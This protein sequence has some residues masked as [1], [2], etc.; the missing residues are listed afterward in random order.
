MI[1][2]NDAYCL[3]HPDLIH[4]LQLKVLQFVG[5]SIHYV[6]RKKMLINL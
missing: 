6:W 4:L 2:T 5:E 3:T 1:V